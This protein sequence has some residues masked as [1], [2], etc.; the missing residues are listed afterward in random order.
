MRIIAGLARGKRLTTPSG[1]HTRPTTDRVKESIFNVIQFDVPG[2]R[3]LDLF[4][5][6]GQLGLEC[7]SRGADFCQFCDN[8]KGAIRAIQANITLCAMRERSG[9]FAGDW[10]DFLARSAAND[11]NIILLDP[12]YGGKIIN[13]ALC[14]IY[15]FDILAARGII[16]CESAREDELALPPA[17]YRL[18]KR[19]VYG[20][21]A[22]T[23]LTRDEP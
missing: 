5:G 2:A 12:P 13:E 7:L 16:V 8:D 22:V 18:Q 23:T 20:S 1:L 4:S 10:K 21:T 14:G 9:V 3:V 6:S 15:R 11:Y 19:Y 17:P